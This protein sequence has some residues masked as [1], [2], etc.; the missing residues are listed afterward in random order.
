MTMERLFQQSTY[1]LTERNKD[2]FAQYI[3]AWDNKLNMPYFK[4]RHEIKVLSEANWAAIDNLDMIVKDLDLLPNVLSAIQEDYVILPTDDDDW[5]NP[6]ISS[7]LENNEGQDA[8]CWQMAIYAATVP[9]KLILRKNPGYGTNSYAIYRSGWDKMSENGKASCLKRH[10]FA[11]G[12]LKRGKCVIN[13]IRE[14]LSAWNRTLTSLTIS[15]NPG[16]AIKKLEERITRNVKKTNYSD[17][18]TRWTKPYVNSLKKLY[19]GLL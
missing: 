17:K 13:N 9:E 15:R 14:C 10:T 7:V 4:F 5:Y 2:R 11:G 3:T 18:A 8:A 19:S 12:K 16:K 6:E 1:F